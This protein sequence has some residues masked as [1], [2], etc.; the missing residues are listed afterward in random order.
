MDDA[1]TDVFTAEF[2]KGMESLLKELAHSTSPPEKAFAEE[3][4]MMFKEAWDKIMDP[5]TSTSTSATPANAAKSSQEGPDGSFQERVRQT[6]DKIKEG[7]SSLKVC[8]LESRCF[9]V[10]TALI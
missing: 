6:M 9:D 10:L 8:N 1:F 7:E 3:E 5:S 2:A 4:Q